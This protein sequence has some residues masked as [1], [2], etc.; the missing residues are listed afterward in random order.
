MNRIIKISQN[1]LATYYAYMLEYQLETIA[2]ALSNSLPFI[3]M[4]TW[5]KAAKVGNFGLT[6]IDFIHYFLAAFLARQMNVVWVI[7]DFE[8]EL[9]EGKLSSRLLQPL[10]PVWHH[11]ATHIAERLSRLPFI[12]LLIGLFFLLYPQGFWIPSL[13]SFLLFLMIS[14]LAF[15]L[16][17]LIQYTFALL[18]FWI[19]RATAI[20][21]LWYLFYLFLSGLIAP[22]EVFPELI[23][24]IVLWTP[25]PYFVYFPAA[26]LIDFP[27]NLGQGLLVMLIW[28]IIFFIVNRWLWR[29]GLQRYSGMGA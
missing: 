19:E 17:F 15:L 10:D 1:L 5:I 3:L 20:E 4:G 27:V 12:I 11:L 21:Q 6:Q 24:Q 28:G 23:H 7:W 29:K 2:W 16:R 26:L 18:T 8:R 25:F 13:G 9:I 14:I 22:I